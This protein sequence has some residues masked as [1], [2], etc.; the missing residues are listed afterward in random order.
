MDT[1]THAMPAVLSAPRLSGQAAGRRSV[2]A[3]WPERSRNRFL[4]MTSRL[5][6]ASIGWSHS[7]V[8][9]PL[10]ALGLPRDPGRL[11]RILWR[12][13]GSSPRRPGVAHSVRLDHLVRHDVLRSFTWKRFSLDWVFI[14]DPYFTS[15]VSRARG[16]AD[17]ACA[18]RIA[19]AGSGALA[20]TFSSALLHA[21]ALDLAEN[22]SAA[23]G[24][25]PYA[26]FSRRSGGSGSPRGREAH[27]AFFDIGPFARAARPSGA[28][29]F[30]GVLSIFQFTRAVAGAR[31]GSAI[32]PVEASRGRRPVALDHEVGPE[33]RARE[34]IVLSLRLAEGVGRE[35]LESWIA[36]EED[37]MLADDYASWWE[38]GLLAHSA[39]RVRL[40][41][42]GFLLSN[43]ILCRF[44]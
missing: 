11:P 18:R 38:A 29:K 41:E 4:F 12:S 26:Q 16:L 32:R 36:S 17:L 15:I 28:S 14:L 5:Q 43:E 25:W 10:F 31:P 1:V 22:G 35:E 33:E 39:D 24:A 6:Y 23:G 30:S 9:L 2:W 8:Y 7:F 37:A 20:R 34:R 42:R 21:R 40:T 44:V 19:V 13:S 27:V 3:L